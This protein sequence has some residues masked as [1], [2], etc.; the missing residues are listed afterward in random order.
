MSLQTTEIFELPATVKRKALSYFCGL[1][2]FA[3]RPLDA[4][5]SPVL[6]VNRKSVYTVHQREC[7]DRRTLYMVQEKRYVDDNDDR[8]NGRPEPGVWLI[9]ERRSACRID[10]GAEQ[11]TSPGGP[12]EFKTEIHREKSPTYINVPYKNTA[13][14]RADVLERL[15]EKRNL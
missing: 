5:D 3:G 13:D 15:F 6:I 14:R 10:P 12:K 4:A 7:D 8:N 9:Y 1:T 11:I 2:E